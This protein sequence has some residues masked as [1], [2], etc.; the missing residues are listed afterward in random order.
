MSTL[1]GIYLLKDFIQ[2]EEGD[3]VP[4][5]F[6]LNFILRVKFHYN[7]QHLFSPE[8][9]VMSIILKPL[10]YKDAWGTYYV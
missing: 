7:F 8:V 10:G 9:P 5:I 4:H 3:V 2:N 6:S 1:I